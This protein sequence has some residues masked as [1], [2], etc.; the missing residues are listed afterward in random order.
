[1][2]IPLDGGV[3]DLVVDLAVNCFGLVV[4]CV[5]AQGRLYERVGITQKVPMG[6]QWRS[7]KKTPEHISKIYVDFL[8]DVYALGRKNRHLYRIQQGICRRWKTLPAETRDFTVAF[9]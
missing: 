8:G 6:T 2:W 1:M 5:D 4:W 7:Y 3:S 9:L